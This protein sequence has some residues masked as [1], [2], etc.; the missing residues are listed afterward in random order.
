V[1]F[2][3]VVTGAYSR[4]GHYNSIGQCAKLA[5]TSYIIKMPGTISALSM[6]V[7]IHRFLPTGTE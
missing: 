4:F 1:D 3:Y 6:R 2:L 7:L 5:T